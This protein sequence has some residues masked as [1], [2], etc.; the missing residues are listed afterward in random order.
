MHL[1]GINDT[2]NKKNCMLI[3]RFS[4]YFCHEALRVDL[5]RGGS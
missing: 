3:Y 5:S 4:L 2:Y 1:L